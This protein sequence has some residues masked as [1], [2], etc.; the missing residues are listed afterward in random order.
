MPTPRNNAAPIRKRVVRLSL[1]TGRPV[2]ER[3]RSHGRAPLP[4]D[5]PNG[6]GPVTMNSFSTYEVTVNLDSATPT[7][8]DSGN[9]GDFSYTISMAPNRNGETECMIVIKLKPDESA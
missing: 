5:D 8:S 2:T 7:F 6:A 9:Y 4:P 1:A 3:P